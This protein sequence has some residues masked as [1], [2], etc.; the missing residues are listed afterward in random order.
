M[1]LKADTIIF[2]LLLV[3]ATTWWQ[4]QAEGSNL[5]GRFKVRHIT[6]LQG[7]PGNTVRDIQ[8]DG[9]GFLWMAGTGG[10]ARFD[11]YRFVSFNSFGYARTNSIPRHIG[12]LLMSPDGSQLWVS[13]ATY[14]QICYDLR[15]GR[16]V[17]YTGR[18]DEEHPYRRIACMRGGVWMWSNTDGVRHVSKDAGGYVTRDY[19]V[20]TGSLPSNC[21]RRVAQDGEGNVWVA[22]DKGLARI[23]TTGKAHT[24][25]KGV[26]L[27][28]CY[29]HGNSVMAY[30]KQGQTA[31]IY[32]SD[33]KLLRRSALPSAM[34]HVSAMRAVFPW[35]GKWMIFTGDAT[36]ALDMATGV[37]TKPQ[38]CQIPNGSS[39]GH[40]GG[41]W[42]VSNQ[43]S[44]SLWMFPDRGA[45]KRLDLL[46]NPTQ[47]RER[48]SVF[49][50]AQGKDG[51]FY[52]GSYGGGLFVYDDNAGVVGH[53]TAEDRDPIIFSNYVLFVTTDRSGCVWVSA[54]N[55][56]VS[57]LTPANNMAQYYLVDESHQGDWTNDVLRILPESN[58]TLQ[59]ETKNNRVYDFSLSTLTFSNA[60]PVGHSI[61]SAFTD[62]RH[63]TWETT[64][65]EGLRVNGKTVQVYAGSKRLETLDFTSAAE[66]SRGRIWIGTWGQGLLL[67]ERIDGL[68]VHTRLIIS[69][70]YNENRVN[71]ISPSS[72]GRLYVATYNGLYAADVSHARVSPNDFV[73]YHLSGG[74]FPADE[75]YCVCPDKRGIVWVGTIGGG[76][77][78]C[79]FSRGIRN[80]TFKSLTVRD[81]L[82][83]DNIRSLVLDRHGY[84]WV[85]TDDG[86]SRVDVKDNYIRRYDLTNHVLGNTFSTNCAS[87]LSDGRLA[88]GTAYGLVIINPAL[89]RRD[90]ART[91]PQPPLI[92]DLRV[93]GAS[94]Y[95]GLDTVI[96]DRALM[97]TDKVRLS[98]TQ[99]SLTFY[100]SSCNY[101]EIPSQAYQYYLEGLDRRW[102]GVTGES[103]AEYSNLSPGNY[104]FHL[105]SVSPNGPGKETV[106]RV[107]IAQPW[108]NTVWAWLVYI[109]VVGTVCYVLWRNA[110]ERFRMHQQVQLEKQVA[111]FRTDFF[112][113][114]THEFRTPLAI[115]QNAVGRLAESEGNSRK[116]IQTAQRGIRRLLRLVNQFL[117]YRRV[118]SGKLPLQVANGD[119]I[120]FV[121]D[122]FHDFL[123]M[124]S[125]KDVTLNFMPFAHHYDVVFDHNL[126]E[127]V[128][129]NL[130]SNAIKYTPD[131][132]TVSMTVRHYEAGHLLQIVVEDTGNG[133]Q[134]EQRQNLFRP[135]MEGHVSKGGMGIGLYTSYRMAMVHHGTLQYSDVTPHG[136]RFTFALP[137]NADGYSE[138]EYAK[139]SHAAKNG[140]E[141]AHYQEVI[142]EMAPK[143]LN[144]Q[145]VAI[146]EDDPD[147]QEQ[148]VREVGNY[149]QTVAYSTGQAG[150]DGIA[151]VKPS[152][153]LCDI[154]L[155]D[156][157]G[158]QVVSKVKSTDGLRDIPVIMLTALDDERHQIKGYQVGA[159]DYMIK[160]CNYHLLIARMMQLIRW[161]ETNA[162]KARQ[163]PF[164]AEP[165]MAGNKPHGS[166]E[167]G[168]VIITSQADKRFREQLEII[169]SRHI[170]DQTLSVDRLAEMMSMGR[171]KF[172]GKVKDIFGMSPNKYLLS[173]RMDEAGRLLE[174]GRYN[175]SEVSYRVGFSD[176]A[177]FN[178]CFKQ[179]FGMVPSKFKE[180]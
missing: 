44:G 138:E 175:V 94:I 124:A 98:H 176:P 33:G 129:Y 135:F 72:D 143:A 6:S 154:M 66:D 95:E 57:C 80:M 62:S 78:R 67:V 153:I 47:T 167:G 158:Y 20:A 16:F 42:F 61:W 58:G 117:E 107:H 46:T 91:V 37:F 113:H 149:F 130:L 104:V 155:P 141:E 73:L 103:R 131:H 102:R 65:G 147:M 23:D 171:T 10:L 3:A 169:V 119:I 96:M 79:D 144:S 157:D 17:D 180:R 28:G 150:I 93:N 168:A 159:D 74:N 110:R 11:G 41:K 56:G 2:R 14:N 1:N 59:V 162:A 148:I 49:S 45:V 116:N 64:R 142:R 13:T 125:Q 152:L 35:Q 163:T 34:G 8:Q 40:V 165:D 4:I 111:E 126:V 106:L 132:G 108:Y 89:D 121:Q 160:P 136:A 19:T 92:S 170:D 39:L 114:V 88:F 85:G 87:L 31:Y 133:I 97:L 161:H 5:V 50:V 32:S 139:A 86:L 15:L 69:S 76:L 145:T 26:S 178:K 77:V 70:Q 112:T 173:R 9:D 12:D 75:I 122:I 25:L 84:L 174:E 166:G 99:N 127:S 18:G 24:L 146:V 22:T 55:G 120:V 51:K 27:M 82:S 7:L 29:A 71:K 151:E 63:R 68:K 101:R 100:F 140:N 21:V 179:H 128:V 109:A 90:M 134:G 156:M 177:Y 52:I 30:R 105:R 115:L 60:R 53:Y 164:V 54:E 137:D 172:Y 43:S 118:E 123:A 83:N 81:G 38:D 48:N 36:F